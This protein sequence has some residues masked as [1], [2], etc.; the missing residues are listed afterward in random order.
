MVVLKPT[1]L[2]GLD[3]ITVEKELIVKYFGLGDTVMITEGKYKGESALIMDENPDNVTMPLIKIDS[4]HIEVRVNTRYLRMR[5]LTD[6][7]KIMAGTN[8]T[9]QLAKQTGALSFKVGDMINYDNFRVFGHVIS[10]DQ[11]TLS[12]VNDQ[13]RIE[14]VKVSGVDKKLATD[15]RRTVHDSKGNAIQMEDTV[16][17]NNNRSPFFNQ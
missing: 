13:G 2:E 9:N 11:D 5:D 6:T 16:F 1:N 17:V 14:T 4:S 8:I 15:R 3:E 12:V 7:E 10:V